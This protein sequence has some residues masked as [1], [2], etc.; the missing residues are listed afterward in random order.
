[1]FSH[2]LLCGELPSGYPQA[3]EARLRL[4]G[5]VLSVATRGEDADVHGDPECSM[6]G[7]DARR[8]APVQPGHR[9]ENIPGL[10]RVP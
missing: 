4:P 3:S 6:A 7:L 9:D 2:E 10:T 8:E 5:P 1:M